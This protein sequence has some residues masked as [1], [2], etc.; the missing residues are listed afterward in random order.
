MPLFGLTLVFAA[1]V[2][3]ASSAESRE[4]QQQFLSGNYTACVA[5]AQ[6]ALQ[7]SS[8]D[9]D[10]QILLS[11]AL[12]TVGR[13]SEAQKVMTNAL[14]QQSRS[15]RLRWQARQVFQSNG[16]TDAADEMLQEIMQMGSSRPWA[17]RD[18]S[19]AVV[20]GEA[21]LLT[22]VDPKKV[23]DKLFDPAKKAEPTL[24]DVYLASGELA[25]EKH[26]F[27]LAAR[28]FQEGLKQLPGDPDLHYGLARAYA[29]SD[30]A[31]MLASAEAALERNSNHIGSLLLLADHSTDAEDYPE[32][33]KLLDRIQQVNPWQPEA[34]AYRAVLA[35]LQNQPQA[36]Q[37]AR[38]TALK[39]W[40]ANPRV[41]HLIGRKLSQNYRFA[42]GA[43]HQ[44]QALQFDANYLPAKSQ[45]AQDLLRLGQEAEGWTLAQEVQ[46]QDAY[47]VQ[48]Y[49]LVT[50]RETIGK[51][52]TLT[53][54]NFVVRMDS[55]EAAVYGPGVLDLLERARNNLCARF[56]FE[57]QR[58]TIVEV[59]SEQ[60]DF[61]VRTFGMPG[62][63]GYLGVCFGNVV[64]ANSPAAH[65][66]HAVNWEAVL[67]HEF[68][69]VVTLQ[70]TRNKMP[71]WLSEGISV[72]EES[73]A[74]PSWGQ[75][76]NPRYRE[77]VLGDQL[78]P[79]S[80]LSGAFLSPPSDL[81]LQFAY[82]E[83]S[84]V[85]EF[86]VERFG[87]D[88]LKALLRDLGQ[89]LEINQSIER[90]TAPMQELEP[91]FAAF[92]RDRAEK[93][94]PGLDWEK[95]AFEKREF[96]GPR[97]PR[98]RGP[99]PS[100]MPEDEQA[101]SAW[102]KS[103]PTNFWV[104]TRQAQQLVE[105]KQWSQAKPVLQALI[106]LFPD[107]TGPDS[108]YR[109]LAAV[110]RALG[111]TNAERQV[112]AQFAEK[113]DEA[114][115]AYLRLMELGAA[116]QNWPAVAQNAQRYLAVNPLLAP[117]YRYLA[118]ASESNG[119]A[120]T[121]IAACRALLEL[122]PADPAELHFR[123]AQL[124]HRA[125]DPD[126]RRHLLQALEEA[127]GYRDALRLLLKINGESLT[128][129]SLDDNSADTKP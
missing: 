92:A 24:R 106:E 111:E 85:V 13:Y 95:P 77:M 127:P 50:L 53:N 99:A 33:E 48:S 68:C 32:A 72:Y 62:N 52:A 25:L 70:M 56:D 124:L 31:L 20:L 30:Q 5:L 82:Y 75:R 39:Y 55:H 10:L 47:D 74:N 23:L 98:R 73:Q 63:P 81:H 14:A 41:D 105:D 37:T 65:P 129:T 69:H 21:A 46:K 108:A 66:G 38:E 118:Q 61:A 110:H 34:W 2:L 115:D 3:T 18:A 88:N 12:L 67:W 44:R 84:L 64:T 36:E 45:L 122:D 40:P 93:L 86:F 96:T 6:Q 126:A 76:M 26:D 49:N 51:F 60:K 54:A 114:T 42:E 90:R 78:T 71:R 89:G 91:Q 8:E 83:S 22:G 19:S 7:H 100:P 58:P 27:A 94:A 87:L 79:V 103:R 57:I 104:M 43:A 9:E 113:D 29:P 107:F 59:F 125:G 121:A 120:Q 97:S 128:K 4:A 16:Q 35:H 102:A 17:Y 11:Q 116:V 15:I 1:Q 117:P 112:L 109:L 101:Y 80:R 28:K 119:E 123:L